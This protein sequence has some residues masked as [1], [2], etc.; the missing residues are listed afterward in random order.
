MELI[1]CAYRIKTKDN[2]LSSQEITEETSRIESFNRLVNLSWCVTEKTLQI[3]VGKTPQ[4]SQESNPIPNC[5]EITVPLKILAFLLCHHRHQRT[6]K[7]DR[8]HRSLAFV[9]MMHEYYEYW[10]QHVSDTMIRVI[11]KN[12]SYDMLKYVY[13]MYRIVYLLN[14]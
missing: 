3:V 8:C 9:S 12:V 10:V 2:K 6:T 14:V 11:L 4:T 7:V 1:L 13:S 5:L